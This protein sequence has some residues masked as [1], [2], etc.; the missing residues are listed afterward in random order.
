[1]QKQQYNTTRDDINSIIR[2][3]T[4]IKALGFDKVIQN[5]EFIKTELDN[6]SL[7]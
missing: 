5:K 3:H 1:M 4:E 2:R 6:K 7:R